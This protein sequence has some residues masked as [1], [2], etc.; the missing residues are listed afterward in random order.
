[1]GYPAPGMSDVSRALNLRRTVLP[2]LQLGV[3]RATRRKSPFQVTLSLT[4]RCNFRC[5]YCDIP[6]QHRDEM[7]TEEWKAK[8][9]HWI[10][11]PTPQALLNA[12]IVFD[13]RG[14]HG[15]AALASALREWLFHYTEANPLF[16]RMM[17][18]NALSVEP[19]LGLIR[20]FIVDDTGPGKGTLD[21]KTRGTRLFV[22]CA[23]VF[24]LAV[25]VGVVTGSAS[26]RFR[27]LV[28]R[29]RRFFEFVRVLESTP[30][31]ERLLRADPEAARF[32]LI[33]PPT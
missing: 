21:L 13:F 23:R 28:E 3:R 9:L 14:L 11:E 32:A 10:R 31:P 7:S 15:D 24:A 2:L 17:V 29:K 1:M 5:E 20:S 22:D 12:N 27:T 18:Q 26:E 25:E 4:N 19:P 6:H 33:T 8:F 16:L 30:E